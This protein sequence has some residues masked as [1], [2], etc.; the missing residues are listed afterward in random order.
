[1]LV[2]GAD[3]SSNFLKQIIERDIVEDTHGGRVIT[4]F[5]PEPNGYLHIGHAKAICI[6]FGLAQTYGG[7]CHLRFDDTNPAKEDTEYVEAI[8]RDIRWLGF[9]WGDKLFFASDSFEDMY[10]LA[11]G[12]V[13]D[14]KAYVDHLTEAEIRD[15]RGTVTEPATPSPHRERPIEEN[16]DLFE[17]MKAGE[18]PDG[19][20]VLRAK[21]DMSSR[22]SPLINDMSRGSCMVGQPR[23]RPSLS[24]LALSSK[25][26]ISSR[27]LKERSIKRFIG[28]SLS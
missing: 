3:Q 25:P 8:Q 18:F 5:P 9:D 7:T 22:S 28:S 16:L 11:E 13:R 2:S 6:N 15:Y 10:Q 19:T 23:A 21:I 26:T 14:G 27:W 4:R 12:L 1:M 20:R 24:N 17:R